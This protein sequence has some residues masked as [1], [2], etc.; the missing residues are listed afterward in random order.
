V[1]EGSADHTVYSQKTASE[2]IADIYVKYAGCVFVVIEYAAPVAGLDDVV[3]LDVGAGVMVGACIV[4]VDVG[5]VKSE[6]LWVPYCISEMSHV[7]VHASVATFLSD[8]YCTPDAG[9]LA[10]YPS[11]Q[12]L[13]VQKSHILFRAF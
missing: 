1:L 12:L 3:W 9:A 5:A 4:A 10:M 2:A 6:H 11:Q 8:R 13:S 7:E